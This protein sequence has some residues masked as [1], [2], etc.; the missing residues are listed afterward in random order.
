V[1]M[2]DPAAFRTTC[3][4]EPAYGVY[5]SATAL[6]MT[7]LRMDAASQ[8]SLTRIHKFGLDAATAEYRGSAEIRGQV[9]RG[10]HADF[11]MN[12]HGSDLRVLASDYDWQTIDFVDHT[13]YVL[14][15]STVARELVIL[16]QL[17]ND[18]RPEEIGKPNEQ[19][20]GVRFLG[21]RAY[22][23]TFQRIDP[24]YVID[25]ADPTDPRIA[26]QLEVNGLS[27]LLHPVNDD[28]LLG[29]GMSATGGVKLELFDVSDIARPLSKGSST[30]GGRAYSEAQHD[31]HAFTYLADA[32]G[33]DRLA[34]PATLY[35]ESSDPQFV[36]SGLYLYEIRDKTNTQLA[37][38]IPVGALITD[39][40]TDPMP[41]PYSYRNRAF[42]HDDAIYY[43]RD[44]E[45]WSAFWS[46]PSAPAGPF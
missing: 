6:Y 20:H 21:T 11:R 33:V 26:G 28:L 3:Y 42:L 15:E 2:G 13:L 16:S 9:W 43:I 46:A 36:E 34:I 27:D 37:T 40:A 5:A 25:L 19:L 14:R 12:E 44:D 8:R 41:L 17:P 4:N 24:L 18:R 39:R 30:L 29:L 7:E 10:G 1:P 45:V 32:D 23:V 38:L 22:A 35:S 31:R